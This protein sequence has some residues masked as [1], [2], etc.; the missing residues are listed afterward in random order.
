MESRE[1]LARDRQTVAAGVPLAAHHHD[2][3]RFQ[4]RTMFG[5]ALRNAVRGVLHEHQAGDAHFDGAPVH[6]AHLGCGQ[7]FHMRRATTMVI[8][9]CSSDEP[10]HCTTASMARAMISEESARVYL[11]SNSVKRSSPYISP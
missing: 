8:S 4:G 11:S 3:L 5:Q 9:S 1:K 10:V 2:A 7:N 6:L